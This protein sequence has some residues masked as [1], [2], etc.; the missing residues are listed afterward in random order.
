MSVTLFRIF[1]VL[2]F[3]WNCFGKEQGIFDDF[4]L[5]GKR[6]VWQGSK[7]KNHYYYDFNGDKKIDA[8]DVLLDNGVDFYSNR[9]EGKYLT[10]ISK[11]KINNSI[12]EKNFNRTENTW[13]NQQTSY[14]S[15]IKNLEDTR[16]IA[17]NNCKF[18]NKDN[19][20]KTYMVVSKCLRDP[21]KAGPLGTKLIQK[22]T[23]AL[24]N[25]LK[26]FSCVKNASLFN[27]H[28]DINKI[29]KSFESP[30]LTHDK[31]HYYMHLAGQQ[32]VISKV[33]IVYACT[34]CCMSDNIAACE[35]CS[36]KKSFELEELTYEQDFLSLFIY[37]DYI[38]Q[39]DEFAQYHNSLTRVYKELDSRKLISIIA[40]KLH[41]TKDQVIE[42]LYSQFMKHI[43][44]DVNSKSSLKIYYSDMLAELM[45]KLTCSNFD[46]DMT[47]KSSQN[48]EIR[49]L[50]RSIPDSLCLKSESKKDCKEIYLKN[51]YSRKNQYLKGLRLPSNFTS[52]N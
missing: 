36:S 7:D 47:K 44:S 33:D 14:V 15:L 43:D 1:L 11:R 17:S 21:N 41:W 50:A 22:I 48:C 40:E 16:E 13:I 45:A 39:E 2:V 6:F 26:D 28:K 27:C 10:K 9:K 24:R 32:H 49:Y 12:E 23:S 18:L 3:S 52:L 42:K 37:E 51:Y 46:L 29:R 4:Y 30:D 20:I 5:D 34:Q 35:I 25:D 8:F 19:L 38:D 31:F